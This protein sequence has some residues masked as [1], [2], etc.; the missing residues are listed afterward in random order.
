[1]DLCIE[2]IAHFTELDA[3]L[4]RPVKEYSAGMYVR[5][6]FAVATTIT[7]EVLITGETLGAGAPI[8]SASA[9]RG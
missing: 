5:L 6:A 9:S 2:E 8:S 4:Q 3:L 7:P 1:M